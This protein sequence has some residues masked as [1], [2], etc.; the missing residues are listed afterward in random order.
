M[1]PAEEL[2]CAIIRGDATSWPSSD[3]DCL[4]Q[5]VEA[6]F[7]HSVHLIFFD[8]LKKSSAWNRWPLRLRE[9]LQNEAVTASALDLIGEQELRKVLLCLD[10]D[11]IQPLL[12]KGVPLAYT[13]YQSPALRPRGDTDLLIRE[14]DLKRVA[15][16]LRELGYDGPDV[17]VDK[18][19]IYACTYRKSS[20]TAHDLDV[21]WKIN[22]ARLFARTLT[23]DELLAEAIEIPSLAC[24]ALGLGQT[25]ALLLACMHRFA[26][27]HAPFYVNGNPIYAGDHLR[28]VYDIHLLSS[29]LNTGQWSEFTTL[30]RTKS[31]AEFCID[32]LSASREAFN[33]KIPAE[34]IAALAAAAR[35]EVASAQSLR[36]SG[37]TWF[38]AN[39]RALP[40]W[41]QRIALI[42]QV[43]LPSSAYMM[44]KYQINSR[45]ALPFLYGYRSVAGV[46]KWFKRSKVR[47]EEI[48]TRQ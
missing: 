23:F 20:G 39:L 42:K 45:L 21:H 1:T 36:A 47:N 12:L 35:N 38:F 4:Q 31:I 44:E 33:T 37:A 13:V 11:G 15:H 6:A 8:T 22:N 24:C 2:V 19:A 26:H 30:A 10:E 25:H 9:R 29:A 46:L 48:H 28:W 7:N 3:D 14:G 18:F 17:E 5:V 16:I 32:G 41:R 27:A 34:T 43:A 40:D